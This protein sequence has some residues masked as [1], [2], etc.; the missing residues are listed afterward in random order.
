MLR[1]LRIVV[2]SLWVH[3]RAVLLR[4]SL[5]RSKLTRAWTIVRNDG[6]REL[7]HA[8]LARGHWS[9][10]YRHWLTEFDQIG[11]SDREAIEQRIAQLGR[12]PLISV[13]VPVFNTPEALLR[14]AIGS[15]REQCYPH[16]E[17]CIA[18]DGSTDPQVRRVLEELAAT[19]PRIRVVFRERNGNISAASNSALEL[20]QG[21]FI[22]LLDHDDE[23]APHALYMVAQ[24]VNDHPQ[25]E[26]VYSDEDKLDGKGRRCE[27]Y[28]KSDW[29]PDLF[30]GHNLLTHLIVYR[31]ERVRE[32]GGFREGF[33][34][35]QD[36]DLALRFLETTSPERICHIPHVLYHWR[37]AAGS[38]AL[39]GRAKAYAHERARKAIREHFQRC[40]I[41]ATVQEGVDEFHHRVSYPI[42]EPAPLVS[43]II[44]TRDKR[45]LLQPC[46]ESILSKSTYRNLELVIMDNQSS[47]PE[48]LAYL[49]ELRASGRARVVSYDAPFNFSAII[50]QGARE[51][52]GEV[53]CLL[54]NDTVVISP[55]W[56]EEMV[57]HALREEVGA[58]GAKLYYGN[59]RIQHA[60]VVLG[61]GGVAGHVYR[62]ALR[63]AHGNAMRAMLAQDY[64]AVTGAC[65][66]VRRDV[67][68]RAGGF[69]EG[70]PIA[71]NDIDFCIRVRNAG[72]RIVWTPHAELYH[73]ESA[74]RGYESTPEKAQRLEREKALMQRRW[75]DQL[76]SDPFYN[77]NLSLDREDV[78][79]AF[80]PR[81]PYPWRDAAAQ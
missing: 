4:P 73:L 47:E 71:Y 8:L 27:P 41:N 15:V 39:D 7:L 20:A 19:D 60:G 70:L 10:N 16:W 69:D 52:K 2:S 53:L 42:P 76:T 78:S 43:I 26:L 75:G 62:F 61:I 38:V 56:L 37:K 57:G 21:E 18:D 46:V 14:R 50:N 28:F 63:S 80:P 34:G 48:T 6:V 65:M 1:K 12:T 49:D 5:L 33:E 77:P 45:A 72:F 79:L 55:D 40:G 9:V 66:V 25:A 22:A 74:S 54:N 51:A 29:N 3:G 23:L 13:I 64:S 11:P 59:D 58:V 24:E 36:Y 67:F 44:P 17:L 68:D 32:I 30:Y 35:S 31:S 81:R